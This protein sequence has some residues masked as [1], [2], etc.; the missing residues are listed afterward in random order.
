[1]KTIWKLLMNILDRI[2][3]YIL[4]KINKYFSNSIAIMSTEL[5]II[6][7]EVKN[8]KSELEEIKQAF[9][10]AWKCRKK[11]PEL[12]IILAWHYWLGRWSGDKKEIPSDLFDEK[13]EIEYKLWLAKYE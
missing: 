10:M 11:Y 7:N 6:D 12:A 2:K 5:L 8:S 4:E 9:A 13:I 3:I 1:M